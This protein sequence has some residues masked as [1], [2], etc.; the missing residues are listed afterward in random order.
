[1]DGSRVGDAD[2]VDAADAHVDRI[3]A[4]VRGRIGGRDVDRVIAGDRRGD[5]D[6]RVEVVAAVVVMADIH[7]AGVEDVDERVVRRSRAGAAYRDQIDLARG[8]EDDRRV[9]IGRVVENAETDP[10]T[11]TFSVPSS[12]I[13]EG[14][15]SASLRCGRGCRG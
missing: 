12:A 2:G 14:P 3:A 7:G 1:V 8:E 13:V 10:P 9:V 15:R 4:H 6:Q 11:M 5:R